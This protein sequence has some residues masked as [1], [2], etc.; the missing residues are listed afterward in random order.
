MR[1]FMLATAAIAS[2]ALLP[3]PA[4]AALIQGELDLSGDVAVRITL[5]GG[6]IDFQPPTNLVA[7]GT[8]FLDVELSSTGYFK[9]LGQTF[10]VAVQELDLLAA[11]FPASSCAGV[12][13]GGFA[14]LVGF[15][16]FPAV[17]L[18]PE[19]GGFVNPVPT[20]LPCPT[21][22]NPTCTNFLGLTLSLT[23]I[24]P[25]QQGCALGFAPQFTVVEDILG[26]TVILNIAGNVSNATDLTSTANTYTGKFSAQFPGRTAAQLIADID[27]YGYI[28]TSI[29][30]SKI[31]TSAVP[32]PA[33]LLLFGTG[34]AVMAARRRRAAKKA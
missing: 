18:P 33:S 9:P 7:P 19:F 10:G 20:G 25:C 11:L 15:E 28:E 12:A 3:K 17:L 8:G 16:T 2:M 1:K 24:I 14:E 21:A 26:T 34:A 32:E 31:T 30:G 23:Q 22:A 27:T 4:E 13:C 6:L 29:S 5:L